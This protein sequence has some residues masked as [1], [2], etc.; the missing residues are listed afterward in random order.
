MVSVPLRGEVF[1]T[2]WHAKLIKTLPSKVSVP[3]RGEVFETHP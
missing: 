3:L 1:E 2:I